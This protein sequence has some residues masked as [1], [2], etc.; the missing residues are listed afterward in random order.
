LRGEEMKNF[1]RRQME[2]KQRKVEEEFKRDLEHN[3]KAQ[4]LLD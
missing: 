4:A 2:T 3:S 1:H